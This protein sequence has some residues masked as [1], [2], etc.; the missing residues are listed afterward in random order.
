MPDMPVTLVLPSGGARTADV[1]DDVPVHD[2]LGELTSLLKLPT[3][4][5]DG[6]P[7]SYRMDSKALGRP[8]LRLFNRLLAA[9]FD[10]YKA[11]VH[12]I[13]TMAQF[14]L[15][16]VSSSSDRNY[17]FADELRRL[18]DAQ[19]YWVLNAHWAYP[20][21]AAYVLARCGTRSSK[22][23]REAVRHTLALL[24]AARSM[25]EL[26]EGLGIRRVRRGR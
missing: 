24:S 14:C 3:T 25:P 23:D 9:P 26:L 17:R 12:E 18:A 15:R 5:P 21:F 7:M 20:T 4:G 16:V 19:T 22:R 13:F 2:L 1:P 6:R 11:C 8:Y 10:A